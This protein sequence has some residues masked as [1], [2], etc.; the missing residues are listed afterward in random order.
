MVTIVS[1]VM[2]GQDRHRERRG[3][4]P[5]VLH[6]EDVLARAVGDVAVT[7]EHDRLVVAGAAGLGRR[8]HRVQVDPGRL[9]DVRDH[10][11]PDPLPARDHRGDPRLLPVL[12]EI[13]PPG[14]LT[15]DDVDG[16]PGGGYPE[17][18]VAEERDRSDVA[19]RQAVRTD[20]LVRRCSKLLDRVREVHEE[21]LGGVLETL[22][23]ILQPE[24][25]RA[26]LGLVA[27]DP[28][29][30][31]GP[32]V[33]PVTAD[34]DPRVRPVDELSVHPDL[35]GLLHRVSAPFLRANRSP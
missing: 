3:Q 10:V 8:Q 29:E 1:R 33:E 32:V 12:P 25:G 20:E 22:E 6:D 24:D 2:P 7:R 30:D 23:V 31:A 18:A 11:R 34:V 17:L 27:A 13:R 19:G 21:H 14:K 4:E 35:V 26:L 9:R 28:L 5:A 16:V 15:I